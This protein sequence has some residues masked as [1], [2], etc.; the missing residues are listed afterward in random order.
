MKDKIDKLPL[1]IEYNDK[2]YQIN[3]IIYPKCVKLQ[4]WFLPSDPYDNAE[5]LFG[6]ENENTLDE[7]SNRIEDVIERALTIIKNKE[8]ER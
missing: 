7:L 2:P 1:N 5:K 6:C 4:Y 3:F 8:W